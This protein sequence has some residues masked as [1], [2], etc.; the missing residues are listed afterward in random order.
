MKLQHTL[1]TFVMLLPLSLSLSHPIRCLFHLVD[2]HVLDKSV[3]WVCAKL[4]DLQINVLLVCVIVIAF[5]TFMEFKFAF[6]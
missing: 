3:I 4:L 6:C 2:N 1:S 5:F